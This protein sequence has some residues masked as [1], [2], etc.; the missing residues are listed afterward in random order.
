[1]PWRR[2]R[3]QTEPSLADLLRGLLEADS[4]AYVSSGKVKST[5]D[6]KSW[7][8][9]DK[10]AYTSGGRTRRQEWQCQCG[11]TNFWDTE[12][13]RACSGPHSNVAVHTLS[14]APP[15]VPQ[16]PGK[17]KQEKQNVGAGASWQPSPAPSSRDSRHLQQQKGKERVKHLEQAMGSL[18]EDCDLRKQLEEEKN[19]LEEKLTDR[20]TIGARLDHCKAQLRKKEQR[21]SKAEVE[22]REAV[23][24][25]EEAKMEVEVARDDLLLTEKQYSEIHPLK[26]RPSEIQQ[27]QAD[28]QEVTGQLTE[29]TEKLSSLEPSSAKRMK[30]E[31]GNAMPNEHEQLSQSIRSNLAKLTVQTQKLAMA[32]TE[33]KSEQRREEPQPQLPQPGVPSSSGTNPLLMPT[34]QTPGPPVMFGPHMPSAGDM[35][36]QEMKGIEDEEAAAQA[37]APSTPGDE[38]KKNDRSKGKQEDMNERGPQPQPQVNDPRGA[39]WTAQSQHSMQRRET[40][41]ACVTLLVFATT[42]PM[43][44]ENQ[45]RTPYSEHD[46]ERVLSHDETTMQGKSGLPHPMPLRYHSWRSCS[47][48]FLQ[49]ILRR[50]SE[51]SLARVAM[52]C[53]SLLHRHTRSERMKRLKH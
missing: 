38:A 19:E 12:R 52:L 13:C 32:A 9:K 14:W 24:N 30:G 5:W 48:D 15:G 20:R 29:L 46:P 7:V 4:M 16:V 3:Q 27:I 47:T 10:G 44:I 11:K 28:M 53:L 23:Q 43:R 50:T 51:P 35:E 6:G 45:S 37:P 8:G 22:M 18:P 2:S 1:M 33:G 31:Q 36:D 39:C 26:V 34:P 25:F 49:D 41:N 17:P 40:A 21:L 42:M